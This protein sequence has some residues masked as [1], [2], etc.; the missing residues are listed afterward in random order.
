MNSDRFIILIVLVAS[1][2]IGTAPFNL[3]PDHA[4]AASIL[5]WFGV[6]WMLVATAKEFRGYR[7]K[8]VQDT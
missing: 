1:L 2:I 4:L 6:G 8:I 7:I 5:G 3:F